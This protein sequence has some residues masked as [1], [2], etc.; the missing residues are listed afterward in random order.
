VN[1]L[2]ELG[3]PIVRQAAR[4]ASDWVDL[5][6]SVLER[7]LRAVAPRTHGVLLDVGCGE[8]PY[9][10]WFLPYVR[11]Y[12]G[13]EQAETFRLTAA[14]S[15]RRAESRTGRRSSFASR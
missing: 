12:I 15:R 2:A 13:I 9:E 8:K 5:Q 10:A 14:A 6:W 4:R 11:A 3:L 7:S 1:R